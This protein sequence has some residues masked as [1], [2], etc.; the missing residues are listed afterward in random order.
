[1]SRELLS[2]RR[3]SP[4]QTFLYELLKVHYGVVAPR[5]LEAFYARCDASE[6]TRRLVSQD[7]LPFFFSIL[8]AADAPVH[9]PSS[10][11]D[12]WKV[13]AAQTALHNQIYLRECARLQEL[14]A[15]HG[16][17]CILLKGFSHA[18]KLYG[19][20]FQRLVRDLDFLI[21][22]KDYRLTERILLND[23]YRHSA[24]DDDGRPL[25][26][27]NLRSW[28]VLLK[29]MHF[30]KLQ[31]CYRLHA[32]IHWGFAT[33]WRAPLRAAYP[34]ERIPWF[35]LTEKF[36]L[37]STTIERL[38]PELHFTQC[39]YHFVLNN[40]FTGLKWFIDLCQY[41]DLM[42]EQLDWEL[43]DRF[44]FNADCKKVFWVALQLVFEVTGR[45]ESAGL[46]RFLG[47]LDCR[48][49][50]W[51]L[52]IYKKRLF[53]GNSPV[54][55]HLCS[56]LLPDRFQDRLRVAAFMLF[57][58][59]PLRLWD[60]TAARTPRFLQPVRIAG[61][62]LQQQRQRMDAAA[63]AAGRRCEEVILPVDLG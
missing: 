60:P 41:V 18:E 53:A 6:L 49:P 57:D 59:A 14:L 24:A 30:S 27:E 19:D 56:A 46:Q 33:L 35:E 1:M 58:P 47:K 10:V 5:E 7:V 20:N 17:R 52:A 62:M 28:E 22:P 16:V 44:V 8:T 4:E 38:V 36:P 12:G 42:A 2:V 31:G 55:K 3:P 9:L 50:D 13:L 11:L 43:I 26:A 29:E 45:R 32:D 39:V 15:D 21:A 34:L 51:E 63:K 54:S 23:G 37:L 25:A 48:V 40:H 61:R